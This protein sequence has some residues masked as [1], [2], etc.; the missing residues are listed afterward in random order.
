MIVLINYCL[1]QHHLNFIFIFVSLQNFNNNY[2]KTFNI[3][4]NLKLINK[5]LIAFS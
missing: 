3:K 1:Y 4:I 5:N 2:L